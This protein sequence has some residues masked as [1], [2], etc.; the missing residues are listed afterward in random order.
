MPSSAGS[1]WSCRHRQQETDTTTSAH[2]NRVEQKCSG[3]CWLSTSQITTNLPAA[4]A[5][6]RRQRQAP[7]RLALPPSPQKTASCPQPA[8]LVVKRLQKQQRVPTRAQPRHPL[9]HQQQLLIAATAAAAA[10]SSHRHVTGTLDWPLPGWQV[11]LPEAPFAWGYGGK[12]KGRRR[13]AHTG[14]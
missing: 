7:G 4:A 5:T 6:P 12:Q 10:P 9:R 3:Q 14:D 2:P 11:D 1:L 8:H 13:R